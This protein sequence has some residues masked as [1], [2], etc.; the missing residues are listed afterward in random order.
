MEYIPTPGHVELRS[1]ATRCPQAKLTRTGSAVTDGP[2]NPDLKHESMERP[3]QEPVASAMERTVQPSERH[4]ELALREAAVL[5]APIARWLLRHG[6][7]YNAFADMLKSVFV[8]AAREELE[9]GGAR[10]THSALSVLSGVHRKDVR[11]LEASPE[12]PAAPRSVS[13]ASQVFTRWITDPKYRSA[14]G[15]PRRLLRSGADN[16]FESLA[17]AV[18]S[19]V[20]PRTVLDE[21]LR[22]GLARL[23]GDDVVPT[24]ASFVPSRQ[25]DELTA[26]FSSNVSDHI[27][28]AVHNLTVEAPKYL[29]QSVFADGLTPESI[30]RL[31]LCARSAWDSAFAS[32]VGEAR[33]RVDADADTES[34]VRMRFGVY[35]YSEPVKRP[36]EASRTTKP[37]T[38]APAPRGKRSRSTHE[39]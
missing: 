28:A 27:A 6:V 16:S 37:T 11:N 34:D 19:D 1:R 3:S 4:A 2:L 31:H 32:I 12:P 15:K 14:H 38:S 23:D 26:L 17:R 13:L 8:S 21:L 29:E 9:L 7:P 24:R 18:S 39:K 20:H 25:L 30:D 5:M 35:F 22:L 36:P 10:P 33:E